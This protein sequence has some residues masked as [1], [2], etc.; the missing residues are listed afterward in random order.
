MQPLYFDVPPVMGVW[1][2]YGKPFIVVHV[3]EEA[4]LI[5]KRVDLS[6]AQ[7]HK[8]PVLRLP[9]DET[10]V[11]A[12]LAS[13]AVPGVKVARIE[14]DNKDPSSHS[15]EGRT[16]PAVLDGKRKHFVH[17]GCLRP[18]YLQPRDDTRHYGAPA[19]H[20]V[21]GSDNKRSTLDAPGLAIYI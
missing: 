2:S 16:F 18:V 5:A 8:L 6:P 3:A 9:S 14:Q 7:M 13:G 12:L 19:S 1:P 17:D 15:E 10:R 20:F 21:W 4:K 11:A